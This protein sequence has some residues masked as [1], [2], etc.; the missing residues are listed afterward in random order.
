MKIKPKTCA[1][2]GKE[3]PIWK[4][5]QG[6]RFCKTCWFS[7]KPSALKEL[8]KPKRIK[9][10]AEKREV[11]NE[12]YSEMRKK[13]LAKPENS[14]CRAKLKGCTGSY[15]ELTVHHT[16]GRGIY[17]LDISTWIPLCLSCHRWVTDHSEE[18]NA[19]GLSESRLTPKNT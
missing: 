17:L 6:E 9:S 16:K 1:G 13:F 5:F 19:L 12:L 10:V 14:T 7:R 15:E 18:A 2:C 11:L 3:R 8:P 4:N